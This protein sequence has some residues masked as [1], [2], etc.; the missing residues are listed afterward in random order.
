[1]I[2]LIRRTGITLYSSSLFG[3]NCRALNDL[4]YAYTCHNFLLIFNE[5]WD[6]SWSI[7]HA[8]TGKGRVQLLFLPGLPAWTVRRG[9]VLS[10]FVTIEAL[11]RKMHCGPACFPSSFSSCLPSFLASFLPSLFCLYIF[12][13]HVFVSSITDCQRSPKAVAGVCLSHPPLPHACP[14]A[15]VFA[16]DPS[17]VKDQAALTAPLLLS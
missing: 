16:D 4:N 2:A 8:L 17:P 14:V 5:Y 3:I 1:M 11:K 6:L 12:T 10:E 7:G 9:Q 15:R 13:E